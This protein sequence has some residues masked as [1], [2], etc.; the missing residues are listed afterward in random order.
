MSAHDNTYD[1]A[2][3]GS[4]FGGS[5]S[6][7]R[8]SEKGY[9]VVVLERGK[10]FR[11]E[12]FPKTNWGVR[13]FLWF[14]QLR[15]FGIMQFTTLKGV[16]VL[17]GSGVGGGS[18]VYANV[19]MQPSD[20]LFEAPAWN[21][22]AD[23]KTILEPHYATARRMLGVTQ[24]PRLWP[25]DDTLKQIAAG[26]GVD[27]TFRPTQVGVF[28]NDDD[29]GE[30]VPD[31]YFGGEG[32]PR[33]GCTHCAGCMVGCRYNAKNTLMKN[34][35]YFAEQRG[36]EIRS[37]A[38]VTTIRPLSPDQADGARYEV[39][40][41]RSTAWGTAR[42]DRVRARH[43]V[44]AAG[45][46][47]TLR[48]L[49]DNRDVTG[50]LPDISPRLG[51]MVRTNSEALLGISNRHT[52]PDNAEGIAITSIFQA[53]AITQIEPVRYSSGSSF[54]R[55][56]AWP[57]IEGGRTGLGRVLRIL[58][59]MLRQP[60]LFLRAAFGSKWAERTTILLVMQTEENFMQITPGRNLYTG[61]RRG[62][63]AAHGDDNTIH[64]RLPIGHRVAR[65]FAERTD[66]IAQA[67]LH[68]SLLDMPTTAHILGGCPLG[69]SAKEG[70]VDLHCE[71]HNYPGL[72]VV[73]GSI[74]P[75]N[76]GVNP[77]LTITALAEYA[78]SHIPPKVRHT[79]D[80]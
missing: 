66:G 36:A 20:K 24:N 5:V 12:D 25:A 48:L 75:A 56:I 22:L 77:S 65:E 63:V 54:I 71:V 72:Y 17:H 33:A 45:V 34:Y 39:V 70:V 47:G 40:Y 46:L 11:D 53:D 57:M 79:D 50:T 80:A 78:M 28:F 8:L 1:F 61:F 69:H 10:R 68:E 35:L 23:W 43:V 16:L 64:A 49:F 41:R 38:H 32:P 29:P 52:P 6:A 14:P 31:P 59:A 55:L 37:E 9:R 58:G 62:L 15:C 60:R 74:M 67:A 4:G 73:D 44:L 51:T 3:I 26:L 2:V 30:T 76:P 42:E 27:D 13:R 19:L 7:L 18:L 21:H